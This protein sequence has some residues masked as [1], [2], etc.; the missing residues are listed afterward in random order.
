[1]SSAR[2]DTLD[3]ELVYS[4]EMEYELIGSEGRTT[5][6]DLV[7]NVDG[8]KR[9]WVLLTR[10]MEKSDRDALINHLESVFYGPVDF[11][12]DEFGLDTVK[13]FITVDESRSISLPERYSLSITV[14]EE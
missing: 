4:Q 2:I 10:P 14:E 5:K 13:A 3:I 8:V 6:G 11:W 1:M 9:K 7:S 12:L